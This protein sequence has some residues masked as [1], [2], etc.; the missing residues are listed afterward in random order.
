MLVAWMNWTVGEAHYTVEEEAK[1]RSH[2]ET[3]NNLS[4]SY[5][6]PNA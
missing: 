4:R 5:H 3:G 2:D 6:K 1:H